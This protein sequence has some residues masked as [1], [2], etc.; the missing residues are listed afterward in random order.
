MKH[1]LNAA[2]FAGENNN[3]KVLFLK[4]YMGGRFK[5][6]SGDNVKIPVDYNPPE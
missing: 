4:F 6:V 1:I 3:S 5:D 2:L